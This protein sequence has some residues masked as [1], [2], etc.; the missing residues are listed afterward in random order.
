MRI[1][2]IAAGGLALGFLAVATMGY[3]SNFLVR[4]GLADPWSRGIRLE[5]VAAAEGWEALFLPVGGFPVA[6]RNA[7]PLDWFVEQFTAVA[8]SEWGLQAEVFLQG[9]RLGRAGAAVLAS[10]GREW[11]PRTG[12]GVWPDREP[13]RLWNWKDLVFKIPGTAPRTLMY[14]VY[15]VTGGE[16]A[17]RQARDLLLRRGLIVQVLL[18]ERAEAYLARTQAAL[19]PPIQEPTFRSFPFYVPLLERKSLGRPE[20]PAWMA[21]AVVYLRESPEDD[22][23]LIVTSRPVQ[24]LLDK[25]GAQKDGRAYFLRRS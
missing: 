2:H 13:P 23:V 24:P 18:A 3:G 25:L 14:T 4:V 20:L 19:L 12:L 16:D 7:A 15:Q 8:A 11:L 9:D 6:E 10:H 17:K 1:A 21:K 5:P 22:G